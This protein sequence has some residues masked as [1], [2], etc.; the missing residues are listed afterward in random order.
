MYKTLQAVYKKRG[1]VLFLA[2]KSEVEKEVAGKHL[3]GHTAPPCIQ[4][5]GSCD[6][7]RAQAVLE[8]QS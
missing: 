4:L 1:D 5:P 7:L 6:T 8:L 2:D 3:S